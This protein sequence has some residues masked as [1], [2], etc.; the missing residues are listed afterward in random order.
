MSDMP[1]YHIDSLEYHDCRH[2]RDD[3]LRGAPR[4]ALHT[5][6]RPTT[7]RPTRRPSK[8][9]I[10]P[11]HADG[12]RSGL[13]D[14]GLMADNQNLMDGAMPIT[15]FF[16]P[17][18][19]GPLQ[20]LHCLRHPPRGFMGSIVDPGHVPVVQRRQREGHVVT[21]TIGTR[22]KGQAFRRTPVQVRRGYIH[23][24]RCRRR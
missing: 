16:D 11:A 19:A 6:T 5:P 4:L 8:D 21:A 12:S 20:L 7:S 24:R 17:V 14:R 9:L 22:S 10:R 13:G 3:P 1:R 18:G 15:F 23:A 2:N